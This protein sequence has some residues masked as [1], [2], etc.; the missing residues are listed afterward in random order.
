MKGKVWK[1]TNLHFAHD[2]VD[3]SHRRV[4]G[5][6]EVRFWNL[7]PEGVLPFHRLE[8]KEIS[9]HENIRESLKLV[10]ST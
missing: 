7:D 10:C 4:E 6:E 2:E 9:R 5:L 1:L 3:D 8:L